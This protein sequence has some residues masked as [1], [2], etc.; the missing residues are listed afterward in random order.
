MMGST[1]TNL[2][3]ERVMGWK[4]CPDRYLKPG[5]TWIPKWRF[6]PLVRLDDA[7]LLLDNVGSTYVLSLG[8]T[9]VFTAEI[10][11]GDQVGKCSGE[12]KARAITL[13][14]SQAL[15]IEVS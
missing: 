3:A 12:P 9:G 1:L 7:F 10:Q 2:L 11:I 15:G 4:V 8:A 6:E 13:A 14:I 5:R